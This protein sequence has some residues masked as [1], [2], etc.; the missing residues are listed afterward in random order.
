MPDDSYFRGLE[1]FPQLEPLVDAFETIRRESEE[2]DASAWKPWP[3]AS[4]YGGRGL[5]K[6]LP[7][8]ASETMPEHSDPADH[9]AH[10]ARCPA[11]WAAIESVWARTH[12][13]GSVRRHTAGLSMLD[14]G[15]HVYAHCDLRETI[16]VLRAHLVLA[17]TPGVW[18]RI[19][20][21]L[22]AGEAG[23]LYVLDGRLEHQTANLSDA[24]RMLL[25]VDFEL[26]SQQQ[27]THDA[28]IDA[29]R[30]RDPSLFVPTPNRVVPRM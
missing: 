26:T 25:L 9:V 28:W 22:R 1:Q 7:L 27:K 19:G 24:P 11:T 29:Q 18:T 16:P 17:A 12:E 15:T 21:Q 8:S 4:A 14:P 2:F 3:Q 10:R 13:E 6:V 23:D 5:W 30:A 20:D